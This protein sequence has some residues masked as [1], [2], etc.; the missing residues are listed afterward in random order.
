[1]K[2]TFMGAGSSVFVKKVLGDTLMCECFKDAEIALYDIDPDRLEES[3]VM[4]TLLNKNINEIEKKI[5]YTFKDKTLLQQ[6][7]T[8][9]SFC[10]EHK[11][12]GRY[13]S[14]EVLEFFGDGILSASIITHL[15]RTR[16]KRYE[17]GI[18]TTLSEG[19]F[20]NIRSKLS[21]KRNL[22]ENVKRL[23]LNQ[24]LVMGNGDRLLGIADEASVAEDLFESIIGAVYIDSDFS[25]PTVM[26]VVSVMLDLNE[27]IDK[28]AKAPMQSYKNA[29]QEWC[30]DKK[31]RLPAPVYR[32]ISESGPDHNK[33]Y[34][35]AC[36]IGADKASEGSG[37]SVK[38]AETEAA[39]IAL[40]ALMEA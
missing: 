7:F 38:I 8:R 12:D 37:R 27:Y 39:R 34:V 36:Y 21:D 26:K 1:M 24:Y 32:K 35:V 5:H 29:L 17:H 18:K 6:A 13:I 25:I 9:S 4:V 20:S 40:S 23:G 28:N 16:S 3:Y 19:D 30:A 33:T 11:G 15:I 14:N 31:R 2:I 10:N 22:S